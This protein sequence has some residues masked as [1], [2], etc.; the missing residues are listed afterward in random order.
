ML[1]AS[2][3]ISTTLFLISVGAF[4]ALSQKPHQPSSAEIFQGIRKLNV[5]G[6]VL[7]LAAHPDDENTRFIAYCANE[8][9]FNTRYLSL[10]RGDGGQNLIGPELREELGVIRTQELLAARRLDGGQQSFSRANDFGYSKTSEETLRIWDREKVLEDVVYAIRKFRPDIIVCRFPEDERA[11]HGHHSASAIIG[12]EAFVK[13]ADRYVFEDH[14]PH[15]TTWQA[16]RTVTNIGRWW[17]PDLSVDDPKVVAEDI[18]AYNVFLGTSYNELA[19]ESRSQHRS[20]G[21]GSTG[22]R[23]E[24]LE[25]FEHING[26]RADSSIFEGVNTSWSRV[27]GAADIEAICLRLIGEYDF[28]RP[29]KSV[30]MLLQLRARLETITDKYWRQ[31]KMAEVD[32]LIVACTGLYIEAKASRYEAAEGDSLTVQFEVVNRSNVQMA[33]RGIASEALKLGMAYTVDLPKNQ[34][35]EEMQ[36]AV[37]PKAGSISQPYWLAE[38]WTDGMYVVN[39]R[40]MGLLPENPP[41]FLVDVTLLI[42]GQQISFSTPLIFKSN[43]PVRG[44]VYRPFVITPSAIVTI[45]RDLVVCTNGSSNEIEV[46][47]RSASGQLDGQ[48]QMTASEGWKI[49][50]VAHRLSL[51]SRDDEQSIT[52]TVTPIGGSLRGT[53]SASFVADGKTYHRSQRTISYDHIPAQTYF[54]KAAAQLSNINV[55]RKGQRIGYLAG[56][57]DAVADG[58]RA[59]GYVV[60]EWKEAD[61]DDAVLKRYDA[62]VLGIRFL[63]VNDRATSIMP[64]LIRFAESGGNVIVQYNT[65]RGLEL[66]GLMPDVIK[67]GR[68][69][70][71]EENAEVRLLLP[72]HPAFNIPNRITEADFDGW[73]QERGLYF[74]SEWGDGYEALLSMNDTGES[75]KDGSLL[76]AKHGKGHFVYTGLSFFRQ[77]PEGVPGAYRLLAN[78]IS[79]GK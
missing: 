34:A 41:A 16:K 52:V 64:K 79:L 18:G 4:S 71:T 40:D 33:L 78:L 19:A 15:V 51:K 17:N 42:D 72:E 14:L 69:R 22:T 31:L 46:K 66:K 35:I 6:N 13:A 20:Q 45:G 8:K 61:L 12:A 67:L 3:S 58:L 43:D 77:L 36:K 38:D 57:G 56:A 21:F 9:L 2:S 30:P 59:I 32:Q 53:L 73:S 60:D 76:I 50:Q 10:T 74:A 44:E 65:S 26:L 54:P 55:K 37:V 62:I 25:Y 11:G 5:L 39:N 23:G 27:H 47:V 49:S 68:D 75:P 7:Y 29:E 28:I 70:V 48:L 1:R 24:M 63:N